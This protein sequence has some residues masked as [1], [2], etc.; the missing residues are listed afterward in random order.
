[1]D[2]DMVDMDMVE[3]FSGGNIFQGEIF[4][5]SESFSEMNIF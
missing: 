3:Y 4:F 5:R 2:M 1:M